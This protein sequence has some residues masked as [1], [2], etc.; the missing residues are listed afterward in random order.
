MNI[1][2]A[3]IIRR[4]KV[5][6]SMEYAQYC[7]DSCERHG[8]PYEFIDGIEFMSSEDAFKAVGTYLRPGYTGM[9]GHNNCHASHIKAWRR[10]IEIGKPCLI[11]EHDAVVK[12][13]VRNIDIPDMSVVTFGHRVGLDTMYE[14]VSKIQ[15][16]VE[17]PKAMG[18]HACGL[19]PV[20]AQWIIDYIEKDGVG[21]NVDTWL[22]IERQCGIPLY[23]TEP[24][25]VV[26]WP[27]VSTREW[28][29]EQKRTQESG[30]TWTWA[31]SLTPGWTAGFRMP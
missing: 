18:V 17:I 6:T 21:H 27:R 3:L 4:R 8:L 25:Q 23:V 15:K 31:E 28:Q 11:L 14:P 16:L 20:T 30:A 9:V 5:D 22:M 24:P 7:A 26:C 13:D 2:R 1:D 12:G 10:L 19:T 29:D